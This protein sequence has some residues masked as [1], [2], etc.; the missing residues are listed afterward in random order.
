[1]SGASGVVRKVFDISPKTISSNSNFDGSGAPTTSWSSGLSTYEYLTNIPQSVNDNGRVGISVALETFDLRVKVVPQPSVVGYSHLRMIVFADNEYDGSGQVIGE[2]LGDANGAAVS[3]ASGVEMQWL[4]PGFFGRFHV[5][6]D[7][8]WYWYCSST[9][10]SFTED[11]VNTVGK[12]HE[13]HHDMRGHR[14]MWDTTD[15]SGTSAA[16][17]GHIFMIFL[18]SNTVTAAGGL[19]T[20]TTANPP[21]IQYTCRFRYRDA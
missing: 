10:N 12:Y 16:R 4:Q 6:E 18:F 21:T 5:I 20:V 14:L 2:L 17:K 15:T 19:P 3:I 1:M 8:N 9:A 13:S 11:A 7:K